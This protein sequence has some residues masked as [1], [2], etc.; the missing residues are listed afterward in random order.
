MKEIQN[1]LRNLEMSMKI[2]L[3]RDL[4][5]HK[6]A[7]FWNQEKKEKF[8]SMSKKLLAFKAQTLRAL[9]E[10]AQEMAIFVEFDIFS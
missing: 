5:F 9:K 6:L 4:D 10:Y 2:L 1:T 7:S 3:N 8:I